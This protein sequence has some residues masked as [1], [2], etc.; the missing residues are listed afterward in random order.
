[1]ISQIGLGSVYM[2]VIKKEN[3]NNHFPF[4]SLEDSIR[5]DSQTTLKEN[6]LKNSFQALN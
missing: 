6:V 5:Y 4:L 2:T 3:R 1:M